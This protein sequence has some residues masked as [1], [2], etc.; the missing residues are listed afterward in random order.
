VAGGADRDRGG[1]GASHRAVGAIEAQVRANPADMVARR[2]L[3]AIWLTGHRPRRA[4]AHLTEAGAKEPDDLE[5]RLLE[6]EA[7][8]QAGKDAE[9][10]A[11]FL[12]IGERDPRFRYGAPALA[13]AACFAEIGKLEE[14]EQALRAGLTRNWF[15]RALVG[16]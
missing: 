4:L 1:F 12:A 14:A 9:A 10:A 8:A 11:G 6:S 3:A 16:V 7:L 5:L 13:A 15:A 2:E